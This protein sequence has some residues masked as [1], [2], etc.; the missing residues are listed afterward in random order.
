MQRSPS[1]S[2]MILFVIINNIR[3]YK[4]KGQFFILLSLTAC[5]AWFV[6]SGFCRWEITVICVFLF[7]EGERTKRRLRFFVVL[8]SWLQDQQNIIFL[9]FVIQWRPFVAKAK[10]RDYNH[11]RLRPFVFVFRLRPRITK[12]KFWRK[13]ATIHDNHKFLWINKTKGKNHDLLTEC[14]M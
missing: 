1:L 13:L 5:D 9:F 10:I 11:L 14:T 6:P 12:T 4:T 2:G 8:L 3:N 7:R